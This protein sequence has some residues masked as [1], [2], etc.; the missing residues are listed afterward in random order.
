[1]TA[2]TNSGR[3][4]RAEKGQKLIVSIEDMSQRRINFFGYERFSRM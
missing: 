2:L 3:V 1:M 4:D